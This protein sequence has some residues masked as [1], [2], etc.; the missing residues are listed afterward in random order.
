MF[1]DWIDLTIVPEI[2][3]ALG[4]VSVV[5]FGAFSASISRAYFMAIIVVLTLLGLLAWVPTHTTTVMQSHWV[6]DQLA[7]VLKTAAAL[8][9]VCVLIYSQRSMESDQYLQGEYLILML[10]ALLGSCVVMSS[11]HVLTLFVGFELMSLPLY[12]LVAIRSKAKDEQATKATEAA[13]K[14]FITGALASACFLYGLSL[15]FGATGH[16]QLMDIAHALAQLPAAQYHGAILGLVLVIV[17]L[18]FKL[19]L[20]PFHIWVPDVY[21]GAPLS[22]TL[23]IATLPKLALVA[24]C[25]R[26]FGT[27]LTPLSSVWQPIL[28]GLG[29]A[30]MIL[31]NGIALCQ[32]HVRRL[33]GYSAI[34]HMGILILA[35][36]LA[37]Q[38]GLSI[39]LFYS[40][41]Y[42]LTTALV[43][44]GL[45]QLRVH[46]AHC[47]H[48]ESLSGLNERYPGS[49]VLLLIGIF[50]L[51]GVPPIVGFM[52]KFSLIQGLLQAHH[53]TLALTV[54]LMACVA[55]FY[56]IRLI[57]V[58][59]FDA[60]QEGQ[61]IHWSGRSGDWAL[62]IHGVVVLALGLMPAVL[63]GW[64]QTAIQ[65]AI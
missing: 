50:S 2:A 22:V 65:H 11:M 17:A 14:Y 26:L 1:A 45:L 64:S 55:C 31:G 40:L 62:R 43:F 27:V 30:S 8:S 13:I 6:F 29:V 58:M 10:A 41:T 63:M 18:A 4:L 49:A 34:G 23:L 61:L 36:V 57:K 35:F 44:G 32:T 25:I 42:A 5:L 38:H 48:I 24:L 46:G 12:A 52:A 15:I 19:G 53:T 9:V 7:Y 3:L 37:Q 28:I 54:V 33:L 39:A 16:M 47:E 56:Y 20:A 60:P 51:A 21:E 59:Y